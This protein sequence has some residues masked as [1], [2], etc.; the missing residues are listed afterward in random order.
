MSELI[1][2]LFGKC[3]DFVTECEQQ[4]P[5]LPQPTSKELTVLTFLLNQYLKQVTYRRILGKA[6]KYLENM[7]LCTLGCIQY[8]RR[9]ND[10]DMWLRLG[11]RFS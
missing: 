4:L 1:C 7:V 8:A 10:I 11:P 3:R 2:A 9:W 6:I 5:F